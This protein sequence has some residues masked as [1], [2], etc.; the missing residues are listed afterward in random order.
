[1]KVHVVAGGLHPADLV[2]AEEHDL[3]VGAYHD[4]LTLS[5]EGLQLREAFLEQRADRLEVVLRRSGS[6]LFG[7]VEVD[8]P[9]GL[10]A[11]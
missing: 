11:G 1:M 2:R 10:F 9:E 7:D 8:E 6:G 4:A 5:L 3:A